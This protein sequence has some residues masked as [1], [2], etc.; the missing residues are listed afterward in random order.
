MVTLPRNKVVTLLG[1]SKL[2]SFLVFFGETTPL[3]PLSQRGFKAD[4]LLREGASSA[5]FSNNKKEYDFFYKQLFFVQYVIIE[6]Q[7]E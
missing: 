2:N 3:N 6:T 5:G 7:G 4:F 1:I